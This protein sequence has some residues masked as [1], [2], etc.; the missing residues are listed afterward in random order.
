MAPTAQRR[1]SWSI[2]AI[3]GIDVR[4]HVTFVV[5]L[6]WIGVS[7]LVAGHGL[8][9]AL[10]GLALVCSLFFIVVLHELGHALV[11]RRFGIGTR[12]ITLLPIGGVARLERMPTDPRQEF[13]VAIAGPAVN[14]ALALLALLAIVVVD[15]PWSPAALSVTGGH[16]LAKLLWVNVS[17]AVFNLLPAFPMDGGRVLRALLT[18]RMGRV[19]ATDT[20]ARIGQWIAGGLAVL[21]LFGNP[22]LVFIALFVFLGAGAEARLVHVTEALASVSVADAMVTTFDTLPAEAS[23]AHGVQRVVRTTQREFPVYDQARLL[24]F[25]GAN[26]LL[27]AAERGEEHRTIGSLT[28]PVGEVAAPGDPVTGAL[29]RLEASGARVVPVF[30]A[31]RLVG[32]LLPANVAALAEIREGRIAHA[33]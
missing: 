32:L 21:G 12:D 25:V 9:A 30:A 28:R 19:R 26:E 27:G 13:L 17:L 14:A 8:G 11:A 22:M 2:G 33:H 15:A 4:M 20:A 18:M 16:L 24:G 1:W 23:V 3:A 5:L 7:H 31:M 6:G 29:E 10:G